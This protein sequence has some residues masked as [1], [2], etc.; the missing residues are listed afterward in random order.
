MSLVAD[1]AVTMTEIVGW[2]RFGPPSRNT[3]ASV[4]EVHSGRLVG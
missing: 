1:D 2:I 3:D 4:D